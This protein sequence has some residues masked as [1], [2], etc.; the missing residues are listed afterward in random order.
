MGYPKMYGVRM[1]SLGNVQEKKKVP[2][3]QCALESIP[4][5]VAH[6]FSAE[7]IGHSTGYHSRVQSLLVDW[8]RE[9]Y[10]EEFWTE[11]LRGAGF[12]EKTKNEVEPFVNAYASAFTA[13]I[14]LGLFTEGGM[15][16]KSWT[17]RRKYKRAVQGITD[18]QDIALT[19]LKDFGVVPTVPTWH[20]FQSAY[21]DDIEKMM[22]ELV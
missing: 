20:E 10:N 9:R 5:E 17:V 7:G 6:Q 2:A 12:L 22:R 19:M 18:I 3:L 14:M 15:R 8:L 11:V 13:P 21:S 16:T 4:V 1:M